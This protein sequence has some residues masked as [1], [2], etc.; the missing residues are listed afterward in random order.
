MSILDY[1][2]NDEH[3]HG[4]LFTCSTTTY[5]FFVSL[6]PEVIS[7]NVQILFTVCAH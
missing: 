5:I 1:T 7:G 3:T 2:G 4:E 6:Q